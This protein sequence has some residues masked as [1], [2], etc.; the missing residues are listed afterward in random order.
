MDGRQN[1]KM[2]VLGYNTAIQPNLSHDI[3]LS[4]L[5]KEILAD[6]RDREKISCL[7]G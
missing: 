7:P 4:G 1:G 5:N 6:S 2:E 3:S